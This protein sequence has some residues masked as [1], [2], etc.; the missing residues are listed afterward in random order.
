MTYDEVIE[1]LKHGKKVRKKTWIK[2][3]YIYLDLDEHKCYTENG[4][5]AKIEWLIKSSADEWEELVDT[6]PIKELVGKK[7][8]YHGAEYYVS[9]PITQLKKIGDKIT[10]YCLI[11]VYLT[12][13]IITITLPED[14]LVPEDW[15]VK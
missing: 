6:V 9:P 13:T 5:P 12:H 1:K 11:P 7:I 8:Q 10:V 3:E 15:I 4:I 2:G 14:Y